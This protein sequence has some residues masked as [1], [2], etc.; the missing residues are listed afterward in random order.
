[1]NKTLSTLTIA[2][3][4]FGLMATSQQAAAETVNAYVLIETTGNKLN[5]LSAKIAGVGLS[6]CLHLVEPLFQKDLIVSLACNEMEGINP[7]IT[8]LTK[9]IEGFKRSSIWIIKSN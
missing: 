4:L 2:I 8:D 3:G 5:E 1:M 6:N 9:D 7:A